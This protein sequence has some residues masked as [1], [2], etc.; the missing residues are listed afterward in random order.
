MYIIATDQSV[1]IVSIPPSVVKKNFFFLPFFP[2]Q[3]MSHLRRFKSQDEI[4]PINLSMFVM[5]GSK[6][7][8]G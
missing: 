6:L 3:I 8:L 1:H 5:K 2:K 7:Y 4:T